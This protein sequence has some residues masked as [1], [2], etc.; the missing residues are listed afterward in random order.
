MACENTLVPQGFGEQICTSSVTCYDG[1]ALSCV[2]PPADPS[3]NEVIEAID[4]AICGL[5]GAPSPVDAADVT[6]SGTTSFACFDLAPSANVEEAIESLAAEICNIED[7]IIPALCTDDIALC[8]IV[9]DC[10]EDISTFPD[11]AP[12][13]A[14]GAFN[15]INDV[16][17]A[18]YEKVFGVPGGSGI[19]PD[20]GSG[21]PDQMTPADKLQKMVSA[22]TRFEPDSPDWVTKGADLTTSPSSFTVTVEDTVLGGKNELI[23]NGWWMELDG[24]NL[25]MAANSDNYIDIQDDRTFVVTSQTIGDPAPAV[26]SDSMR[27]YKVETDGTGTVSVVDLR[28]RYAMDGSSF[29]DDSII[30]RHIADLN[31]TGDKLETLGAGA[32]LGDSDF[33]TITYDTKGR[34]TAGSDKFN[35]GALSDDDI[36]QYDLGTDKW[37]NTAVTALLPSASNTETLRHNGSAFVAASNLVNTGAF[38]G[39]GITQGSPLKTFT[40]SS[41]GS[42]TQIDEP[43]GVATAATTGGSLLAG[44]Y[45]YVVVAIDG[46][47]ETIP[48][49]E[50]SQAVD[51]A[52]TTAVDITFGEIVGAK[53]YRVYKG[54]SSGTY[55]EYFEVTSP[56]YTDDA[57][58]GTAGSPAQATD[59]NAYSQ[60]DGGPLWIGSM[61]LFTATMVGVNNIN[62]TIG[63]GME[64]I[65]NAYFN[66]GAP[67]DYYT[68]DLVNS[69][70]TVGQT[71]YG[72]RMNVTGSDTNNWSFYSEAGNVAL[73]QDLLISDDPESDSSLINTAS[74]FGAIIK[75]DY[76]G[77]ANVVVFNDGSGAS[78]RSAIIVGSSD[79]TGPLDEVT[80]MLYYPST[81]VRSG[82]P[83]TGSTFYQNKS[84][85]QSSGEVDGMVIRVAK[86]AQ[87]LHF[88]FETSSKVL[89]E[90]GGSVGIGID[91]AGATSVNS[92]A[93][94]ELSSTTKGFK[95]MEMTAAQA[96]AITAVNSLM[97]YVTST[98]GTFT[99][100]G[101]W[102]YEAGAWVKL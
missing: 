53:A 70:A 18:T 48:S 57:T 1:V 22:M 73:K 11:P 5:S 61:D 95:L 49:T 40:V 69:V 25:T 78:T 44:T 23:V 42:Y 64:I 84:V 26:A 63:T 27:L 28:N 35:I 4:T 96:S 74:A 41:D 92:V 3:L 20:G 14:T 67:L 88:E 55:T 68:M 80:A 37:V 82:T 16:L 86:A 39:V 51:G 31:V 90:S 30:T 71:N 77:A 15:W 17:C 65:Q 10:L 36:L 29:A 62:S 102:G 38:V 50:V 76:D 59:Q 60:R 100:V 8:N 72:I 101:F 21:N 45:Y 94:L 52:T 2:T 79:G 58:A 85:F 99:S 9:W 46:V 47:G 83:T 87:D 54:T 97:V 93:L 75:K 6:Y 98:N 66:A 34:V 24:S 7:T 12:T 89:F 56:S 13:T 19:A 91:D 33:I 81:F 43:S 32:T